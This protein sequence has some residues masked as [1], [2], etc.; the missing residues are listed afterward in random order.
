MKLTPQE[1]AQLGV[2]PPPPPPLPGL[3]TAPTVAMLLRYRRV[4]L[5]R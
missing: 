2:G 3:E 1:L 5:A 4:R